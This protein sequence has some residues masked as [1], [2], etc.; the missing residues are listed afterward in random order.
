MLKD[1]RFEGLV[2][3]GISELGGT[4]CFETI[5]PRRLQNSIVYQ[6]RIF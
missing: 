3:Q 5:G 6:A 2:S 1:F 4:P